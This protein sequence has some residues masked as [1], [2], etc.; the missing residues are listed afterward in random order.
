MKY[1]I[2]FASLFLAVNAHSQI[3][4]TI[5]GTDGTVLGDG[6]PAC[7]ARVDYPAFGSFDSIG[8]YYFTQALFAPRVRKIDTFGIISTVAGNGLVGFTGDSGLATDAKIAYPSAPVD[9]A[10]NIYISD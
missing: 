7:L 8:N 3:I 1:L 2:Y 4:V 6:G 5:S 9:K 10:G